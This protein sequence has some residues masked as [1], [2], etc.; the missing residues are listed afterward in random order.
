MG[1]RDRNVKTTLAVPDVIG[2]V[3]AQAISAYLKSNC[4]HKTNVRVGPAPGA[5]KSQ[6][7]RSLQLA[8]VYRTGIWNERN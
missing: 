8:G 2:K 4:G 5:D 1:R 3:D 6:R 7:M